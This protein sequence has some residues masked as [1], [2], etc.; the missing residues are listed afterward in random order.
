MVLDLLKY[1]ESN[2]IPGLI[3]QCDYYKAYDCVEWRY[4]NRVMEAAGFGPNFRKWMTIFYP[5]L[6]SSPYSAKISVNNHLSDKY[7]IERGIRQG[8]PLSC[9]VWALCIEPMAHK[10][11]DSPS[12]RGIMIR[13]EEIKL[14]LYADDTTVILDGTEESLK[15]CLQLIGAFC[16]ISG[17]NL[18]LNKTTCL[19]I[20][21]KRNSTSRLCGDYG[22]VWATE[23]ITVLGVQI[24]TN[25]K[26][27][28]RLNYENHLDATKRLL[29]PWLQRSLSPYGRCLLVKSLAL[30][31]LTYLLSILPTPEAEFLR[32]M[33]RTFYEF[34]WGGKKDKVRRSIT[35]GLLCDG[36]LKTPDIRLHSLAL[37]TSWIKRWLA[38]DSTGK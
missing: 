25:L 17:L 16:K 3:M 29:T 38:P 22:L 34:I 14:S 21:A 31:K 23:A 15:N 28:P 8:C 11:R 37:K 9:L 30:S 24:S 2:D 7:S 1:T 4:V 5:I 32:K 6:R 18:N 10:I 36:G 12:I 19:W 35:K 27:I 26:E 13:Q 20:G 33:E